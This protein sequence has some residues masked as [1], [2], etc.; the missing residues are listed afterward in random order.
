[1]SFLTNLI[2]SFPLLSYSIHHITLFSSH[3]HSHLI[4]SHHTSHHHSHSL[5]SHSIHVFILTTFHVFSYHL[6]F[7]T[8]ITSHIHLS[9]ISHH[10]HSILLSFHHSRTFH[11]STPPFHHGALLDFLKT[12]FHPFHLSYPP[13]HYSILLS[14]LFQ[15]HHPHHHSSLL[16]ILIRIYVLYT[17]ISI[18][19]HLILFHFIISIHSLSLYW[20]IIFNV[21]WYSHTSLSITLFHFIYSHSH[22][23]I[24]HPTHTIHLISSLLIYVSL[25][26]DQY[27]VCFY[28]PYRIIICCFDRKHSLSIR[29]NRFCLWWQI[30]ERQHRMM[31]KWESEYLWVGGNRCSRS[32]HNRSGFHWMLIEGYLHQSNTKSILS[33]ITDPIFLKFLSSPLNSVNEGRSIHSSSHSFSLRIVN[34]FL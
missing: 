17:F 4:S 34:V 32:M 20:L 13:I 24:F 23:S 8:L 30:R 12:H 1:M 2:S 7:I 18:H 3:F 28:T 14:I 29:R 6:I 16:F 22:L 19:S 5:F 31:R 27:H 15:L 25:L 11:F 10:P 9:F 21:Q 33:R 26:W